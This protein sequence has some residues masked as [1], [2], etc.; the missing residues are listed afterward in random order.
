MAKTAFAVKMNE[1]LQSELREFCEAHGLKQGAFVEK[2]LHEQMERE[3]LAQDLLD[4]YTLRPMESAAVD[5]NTYL[6]TRRK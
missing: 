1:D 4:L 6:K 2:A 3:E 5:F